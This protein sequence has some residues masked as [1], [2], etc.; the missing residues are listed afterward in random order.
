MPSLIRLF[1][2][3]EYTD[4]HNQFFEKFHMRL[5]IAEMLEYLWNIQVG[6]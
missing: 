2:D 1:V 4:R 6:Y 5:Y 3:I